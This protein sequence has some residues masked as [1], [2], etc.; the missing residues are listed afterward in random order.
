MIKGL[1]LGKVV[2]KP[3]DRERVQTY[4]PRTVQRLEFKQSKAPKQ[5]REE[6]LY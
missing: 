3:V 2:G 4:G 1:E 6:Q 5:I